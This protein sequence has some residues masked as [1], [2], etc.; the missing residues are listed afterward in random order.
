MLTSL[1]ESARP[2]WKPITLG[3]PMLLS[4]SIF[5]LILI[6]ILEYYSRLSQRDG[7]I[8]FTD[9]EFSPVTTFS[10]LYLPTITAV[11]YNMLWSWVDLDAKRLEPYFQMSTV[12]GALLKEAAELHYPF[13]FL[14]LVP[15][16]A[17]RKR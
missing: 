9:H 10:Y 17:L 3:A 16:K 11:F 6:A 12:D 14:P 4:I 7:G 8:V 1:T 5:T 2:P 15:I 13:D